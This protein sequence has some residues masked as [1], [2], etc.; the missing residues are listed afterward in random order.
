MP[1]N[2]TSK[3][4]FVFPGNEPFRQLLIGART[5]SPSSSSIGQMADVINDSIELPSGHENVGSWLIAALFSG[6]IGSY[7]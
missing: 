2:Q 7:S 1:A 6:I 5:S 4:G 3:G